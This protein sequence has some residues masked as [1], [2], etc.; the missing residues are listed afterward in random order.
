V[1]QV[2]SVMASVE[3]MSI[4]KLKYLAMISVQWAIAGYLKERANDYEE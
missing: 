2:I 4:E 3:N 1:A